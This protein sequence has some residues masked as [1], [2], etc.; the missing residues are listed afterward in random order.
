MVAPNLVNN[1]S[2]ADANTMPTEGH[3]TVA[4]P[5]TMAAESYTMAA[6][7]CNFSKSSLPEGHTKAIRWLHDVVLGESCVR[8]KS[9]RTRDGKKHFS[10]PPE[11]HSGSDPPISSGCFGSLD[12]SVWWDCEGSHRL[13]WFFCKSLASGSLSA[14]KPWIYVL[15]YQ[16]HSPLQ[17]GSGESI[18]KYSFIVLHVFN[19]KWIHE[20]FVV[21]VGQK[22]LSPT[23]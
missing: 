21:V 23:M 16:R 15:E 12:I 3:T 14:V 6:E 5:H 7:R 20:A 2:I 1:Q 22:T 18:V 11:L 4:Q 13:W 9:R 10:M 17:P 8:T 19:R